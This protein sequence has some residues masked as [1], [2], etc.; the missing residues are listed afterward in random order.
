MQ[1]AL[2]Y[3]KVFVSWWGLGLDASFGQQVGCTD[4][5][6][7]AA[8]LSMVTK[9]LSQESQGFPAGVPCL[10]MCTVAFS[11]NNGLTADGSAQFQQRSK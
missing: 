3:A 9:V 7:T 4:Q 5:L 1:K 8:F 11:L 10:D 2:S 6:T